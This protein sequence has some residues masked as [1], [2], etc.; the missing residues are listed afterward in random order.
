VLP[1]PIL[2]SKMGKPNTQ[3]QIRERRE[4]IM[5]LMARGYN[6]IDIAKELGI[7]RMTINR[8]MHYINQMTSKGLFGL[9]KDTFAT[10]YFNCVEGCNEILRE[11]WKIYRNEE[12]DPRITQW[13]K[14][15]VLRLANEIHNHKFSMFQNGPAIMH[16]GHLQEE[17]EKI[18]RMALEDRTDV[19]IKRSDSPSYSPYKDVDVRDFDKP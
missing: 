19:F 8:D 16:L 2:Y 11:C 3:R 4:K 15:A 13:H 1:Y 5:L 18:R 6:Q 9:A 12:N 14:I 10:M 7:T 17:V